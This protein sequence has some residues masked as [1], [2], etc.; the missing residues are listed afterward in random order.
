MKKLLGFSFALLALGCMACAEDKCA[1]DDKEC[2]DKCL[3]DKCGGEKSDADK[4]KCVLEAAK[5]CVDESTIPS[6]DKESED[7]E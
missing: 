5:D 7:K 1:F 2:I 3:E 4:A 6:E